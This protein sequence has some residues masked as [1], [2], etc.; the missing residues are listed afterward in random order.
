[1]LGHC[2]FIPPTKKI[3]ISICIST[4]IHQQVLS[5]LPT[6]VFVCFTAHILVYI[7][8]LFCKATYK[9]YKKVNI[10][11][12]LKK[13][14][15]KKP[16]SIC[17]YLRN[18]QKPQE[19][20][21]TFI[22]NDNSYKMQNIQKFQNFPKISKFSKYLWRSLVSFGRLRVINRTVCSGWKQKTTTKYSLPL[23][24]QKSF[25]NIIFASTDGKTDSRTDRWT[26]TE[27]SIPPPLFKGTGG[28]VTS[29]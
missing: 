16:P 2:L 12:N 28:I 10:S 7:Y 19:I 29:I 9:I 21:I 24:S 13:I 18:S 20:W 5:A 25:M 11:E 3:C 22:V 23:C 17:T 27:Y 8:A 6:A 14:K 4:V 26:H 1:M 15:I